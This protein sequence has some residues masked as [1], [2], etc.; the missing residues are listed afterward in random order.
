LNAGLPESE[1]F[2]KLLC[3]QSER[4]LIRGYILFHEKKP[5]SYL[6]CPI[7]GEGILIYRYLGYDPDYRNWS[8]GVVL[9]FM[10]LERLFDD[11]QC[12]M[13][14]FTEGEGAHKKFFAT[15]GILC[16]DIYYFRRT[17]RNRLILY[18]HSAFDS[19]SAAF[20]RL[21]DFLGLKGQL[22]RLVRS[23]PSR[24]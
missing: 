20:S 23:I 17:L 4:R 11:D 10:V 9:Q 8:P 16:A 24:H 14:D 5:I 15:E 12:L 22:K 7:Q 19:T 3:E 1:D 18:W 13:F 21:F 2:R 6:Y